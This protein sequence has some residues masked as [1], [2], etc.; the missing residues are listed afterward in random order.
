M[1]VPARTTVVGGDNAAD[2]GRLRPRGIERNPLV[3]RVELVIDSGQRCT[4]LD[5]G[6]QVAMTMFEHCAELSRRQHDI[7]TLERWA[8]GRLGTAPPDR[9]RHPVFRSP[10]KH[11]GRT[12]GIRWF[13]DNERRT[14]IKF[15]LHGCDTDGVPTKAR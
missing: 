15:R 2:G 3:V 12:L 6:G 5:R 4:S 14:P 11:C 10:G 1:S 7:D 13:Y 8:P 9:N